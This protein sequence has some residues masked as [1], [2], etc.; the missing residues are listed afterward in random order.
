MR[1]RF[2][3]GCQGERAAQDAQ[4]CACTHGRAGKGPFANLCV[5]ATCSQESASHTGDLTSSKVTHNAYILSILSAA[6]GALGCHLEWYSS[7]CAMPAPEAWGWLFRCLLPVEGSCTWPLP[8]EWIHPWAN[9]PHRPRQSARD[10]NWA[11]LA[12][13]MGCLLQG[14]EASLGVLPTNPELQG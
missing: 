8:R 13:A 10:A 7:W 11:P 9:W 6:G 12:L 2:H 4:K 14:S 3:E 5:A 1:N